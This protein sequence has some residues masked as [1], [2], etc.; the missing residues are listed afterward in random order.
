MTNWICDDPNLTP[1]EKCERLYG[2]TY[3]GNLPQYKVFDHVG[4]CYAPCPYDVD[5]T[6]IRTRHLLNISTS[7]TLPLKVA[8]IGDDGKHYY[9]KTDNRGSWGY[10]CTYSGCP[11]ALSTGRPYFYA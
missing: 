1:Q 8:H 5:A 4:H 10:I 7:G 3:I 6:D 2:T 11:Y 9:M